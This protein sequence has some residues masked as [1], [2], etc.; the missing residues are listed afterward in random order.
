MLEAALAAESYRKSD[1]VKLLL[2]HTDGDVRITTKMVE[3]AVSDGYKL[4]AA[5]AMLPQAGKH[6]IKITS[7]LMRPYAEETREAWLDDGHGV[8][9][10]KELG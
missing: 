8:R 10:S 9:F 2:D 1:I 6:D 7:R 4:E 5:L 3:N